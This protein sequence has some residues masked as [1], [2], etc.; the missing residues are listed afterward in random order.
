MTQPYS[1]V[2]EFNPELAASLLDHFEHTD[3]YVSEQEFPEHY[4]GLMQMDSPTWPGK[5]EVYRARFLCAAD[6]GILRARPVQKF[7]EVIA[8][9]T[10]CGDRK[11]TRLNSSHLKLSRMPSSA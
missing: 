2:D 5:D 1:I 8:S 3:F 11:S 7:R 10:G 6:N 4:S 9:V